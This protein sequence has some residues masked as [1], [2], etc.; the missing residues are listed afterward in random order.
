M[1][2]A[3]IKDFFSV[4]YPPLSSSL[5][6]VDLL[7]FVSPGIGIEMDSWRRCQHRNQTPRKGQ[8]SSSI[9]LLLK[10]GFFLFLQSSSGLGHARFGRAVEDVLS[11][12]GTLSESGPSL[13]VVVLH[14]VWV[15]RGGSDVVLERSEIF[16]DLGYASLA[17]V[18]HYLSHQSP[19]LRWLRPIG[20]PQPARTR[21]D[22]SGVMSGSDVRPS[23]A[24]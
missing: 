4:I 14:V 1:R 3:A 6:K 16:E 8:S 21:G 10:L 7:A 2:T 9:H 12:D 11:V 5:S 20:H 24:N 13:R 22:A 23:I 17:V 15:D 18:V 19:L